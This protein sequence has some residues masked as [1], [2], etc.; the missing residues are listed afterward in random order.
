MAP[1]LPAA[2]LAGVLLAA[3]ATGCSERADAE[4][5]PEG[6]AEG[7]RRLPDGPLSPR[8]DA[9]LVGLD[10]RV[11]VVGGWTSACGPSTDCDLPD[12]PLLADGALYDPTSDSW[13]TVAPPPFGVREA[14]GTA[15]AGL[16][17]TAY[18]LTGC[19][20]GPACD[21][22]A[23]LLG[24]DPAG[25]RWT[26]HGTVP[27]PQRSLRVTALGSSLVVYTDG[28][29]LG[30][31]PDLLFDPGRSTWTELPADPL[32]PVSDRFAVPVGD[33]LVL[34]GSAVL[35][36]GEGP[37]ELLA[38]FDPATGTWTAL[39]DGPGQAFQLFPTDD[40]P[41]LAGHFADTTSAWLLDP[42]SWTWSALP[43][44]GGVAYGVGGAIGRERA[45]YD[46]P[47]LYSADHG[48]AVL[49][50]VVLDGGTGTFVTVPPIPGS[51]EVTAGSTTALGRD[52][53]A[54]GGRRE[55]G[56]ALVGEAWL[57]TAPGP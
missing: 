4:P 57:W 25:D 11:L 12:D 1:R 24:Y 33:Q 30:R 23:R 13:R 51:G 37:R 34:A 56:G 46:V 6:A 32:P 18:L 38:R 42:G 19:A 22:P 26:D 8:T 27:G 50:V 41:L 35:D 55:D 17:G 48:S 28:T 31:V 40:G 21:A 49:D 39:P 43:D 3:G 16:G 7:W 53:F 45:T 44:H 10:D 47:Y 15:T 14:G 52:L 2:V 54:F 5:A 20:T 9:V 29:A 36:P